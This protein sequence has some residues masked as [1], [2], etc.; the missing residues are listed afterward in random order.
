MPKTIFRTTEKSNFILNL[1]ME[2][3]RAFCVKMLFVLLVMTA[4]SS[5]IFQLT[6]SVNSDLSVMVSEGGFSSMLALL[7]IAMRSISMVFSIGGVA[8]IITMVVGLMR[9]QFTKSAAL[10]YALLLGLLFWGVIT[11]I[12]SFDS[13]MSFFGLNGRDEGLLALLIYG[14]VFYL[15][16]MLRRQENLSRFVNLVLGFGLAQCLWGLLQSLPMPSFPN[17]YRM[18]DPLLYQNL[19]LPSGFTDSPITFA[20]LLGLL[21]A[22][23]IPCA[24]LSQ[25]QKQRMF[26]MICVGCYGVLLLKTQTVAGAIAA[27][28]AVLLAVILWCIKRKTMPA[29]HWLTPL[30]LIVALGVSFGWSWISPSL[31]GAYQTYND[32][33]LPNGYRFYDGGIVWDD[34]FYRLGTSGPYVSYTEHDFDIYDTTSVLSY[35][36][37]EGCRVI[38]KYPML[39]T[40]PDNFTYS[41]LRSSLEIFQND[42]SIDRPYN[43]YIYIAA[44]RGLPSLLLYVALLGVSLWMGVRC[45]RKT[46]SWM[47]LSAIGGVISFALTATV[48]ISVLTV[49]PLF[50]M[51]L[52]I[53]V[54]DPLTDGTPN[55]TTASKQAAK[56][57]TVK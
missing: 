44:T 4:A 30:V 47:Y 39:G 5:M 40:G 18:V 16:S 21:L 17:E 56:K 51:L 8:A 15:G 49:S 50:W 11:L 53:L 36:Q 43:D 38:E 3:Y 12:N 20:M 35:C 48:G 24:M 33:A 26:A 19:Y 54:G 28:A 45:Y 42:N 55:A 31:N 10:P 34:G 29:K 1:D 14:S 25:N 32:A 7:L 46:K 13:E 37:E 22:V 23:A 6:Y 9:K 52:G 2:R 27:V 41:Q 57:R